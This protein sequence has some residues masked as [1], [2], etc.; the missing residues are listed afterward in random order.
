MTDVYEGVTYVYDGSAEGL[1]TA[2]FTAYADRERPD[3][4]VREADFQPTLLQ[5]PKRIK[6]SADLADRVSSGLRKRLGAYTQRGVL[7]A[8]LSG[9]KDAGTAVYRFVRFALDEPHPVKRRPIDDI[10][11]P[12]VR[13]LHDILRA[14]SNE[15]EKIRQFS[16][17]EHL[18]DDTGEVWFARVNPRDSVVPLVM[19]HFVERFNVQPFIL[20]DEV[21]D[22]AG[23][24]DGHQ[25]MFVS[26]ADMEMTLPEKTA[27]E[28]VMQEA[29]RTFYKTLSIDARYNPELRRKMMPKRFWKNLTEMQDD[30]FAIKRS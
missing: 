10:S 13:P 20:Y 28:V 5:V 12:E 29:W 8:S 3:A 16:R 9:R 30:E 22:L 26:T 21:H 24:W 23:I 6:T 15:C 27:S 11:N 7:R 19:G 17:F 25:R 4:V 2:I 18:C 14:I 1:L